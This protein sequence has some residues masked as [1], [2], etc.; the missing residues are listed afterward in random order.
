MLKAPAH[1]LSGGEDQ[2][3]SVAVSTMKSQSWTPDWGSNLEVGWFGANSRP[4]KERVSTA[5]LHGV[6]FPILVILT[7][8]DVS[9]PDLT[10]YPRM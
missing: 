4:R 1:S 9:V 2:M 8:T 10:C 5:I 3:R 7:V 6:T